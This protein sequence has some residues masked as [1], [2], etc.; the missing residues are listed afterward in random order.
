MS[1]FD[2]LFSTP[3]PTTFRAA[4]L[5]LLLA[6]VLGQAVAAV[7]MWTFRGM[8][9]SRAF[10]L[11]I[12]AGGV[13]AAML[14]LA[15]NNSIAAGL[16][17]A[18]SLAIIRF[19]TAMRDP[20]DMIFVFAA[21]AAGIA[22]GLRAWGAAIAGTLVFVLIALALTWTEFG[23]QQRYDGLLRLQLPATPEA[24]AAVARVLERT[25][26]RFALVTL[27]DVAQGEALQYAYQ[28]RLPA[29]LARGELVRAIEA[30][31]GATD[32]SLLLQDPTV[33]I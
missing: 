24:E 21:L 31:A 20:R 8:S 32:V 13:I 3:A 28:V 5:S 23:S 29:R 1:V 10:V 14:M 30:I 18:G 4:L 11:T 22:S 27:R 16:G 17:I 33:E 25:T 26:R 7:Y 19:R 12:A 9:Y 15:I 6:F 2:S